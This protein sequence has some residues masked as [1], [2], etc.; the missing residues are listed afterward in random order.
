MPLMPPKMLQETRQARRLYVG[1]VPMDANSDELVAFFNEAMMKA[2]L[3]R[4]PP[5][6]PPNPPPP[7]TPQLE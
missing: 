5:N 3:T 2:T 7:R 1:N 6:Y 4:P